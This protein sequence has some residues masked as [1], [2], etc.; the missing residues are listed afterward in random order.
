MALAAPGID[1]R[2]ERQRLAVRCV[3]H[4]VGDDSCRRVRG[5]CRLRGVIRSPVP[6]NVAVEVVTHRHP[7]FIVDLIGIEQ[8]AGLPALG[9]NRAAGRERG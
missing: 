5:I 3:V 7:V 8:I 9:R 4:A 1:L 2:V 6:G